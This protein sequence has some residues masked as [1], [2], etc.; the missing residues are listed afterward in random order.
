MY[1]LNTT[2]VSVYFRPPNAMKNRRPAA[3]AALDRVRTED[4]MG[5]R[6]V[7]PTGYVAMREATSVSSTLELDFHRPVTH[8]GGIHSNLAAQGRFCFV[9][10]I[11]GKTSLATRI[12]YQPNATPG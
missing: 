2:I 11:Q 7:L 4:L 5:G 10:R 9:A 3:A 1:F 6:A 8:P 12:L